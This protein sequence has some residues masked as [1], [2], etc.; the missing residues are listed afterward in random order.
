MTGPQ[1]GRVG[2]GWWAAITSRLRRRRAAWREAA[3]I[4][5]LARRPRS[6]LIVGVDAL[7][8]LVL[9][10]L[11][12]LA[13]RREGVV[14]VPGKPW[15]IAESDQFLYGP[16]SAAWAQNALALHQGRLAD[17]DPHR[18]PTWT[19]FTV[20]T[21]RAFD[22]DVALAGHLVNR[23]E[24][25]LLGP[26]LYL[27][28]RLLGLRG[29]AFAAGV[30][31]VS[32]PH[33]LASACRFGIDPTVT[34]LVPLM[35]LAARVAGGRW[36]FAPVAGAVAGL[37]MVS[38]LTALAFP[39][40]GLLLLVAS[41][42]GWW[43]RLAAA[44][45]YSAAVFLVFRWVF[46]VF[47]MLPNEFFKD[48]LAEGIT[49]T[50][51][52]VG[53]VGRAAARESALSLLQ[54]NAPLALNAALRSITHT[55][56]PVGVPWALSVALI[57]LGFIGPNAVRRVRPPPGVA[58]ARHLSGR[59][60]RSLA[61]GVAVASAC[62]PLI[63]FAAA[64]SPERYS[65]NLLPVAALLMVRGGATLVAAVVHAASFLPA[66]HAFRWRIEAGIAAL[67]AIGWSAGEW[68]EP[69]QR[70][71]VLAP[72][73]ERNA[74]AVGRA[75]AEHF[76]AGIGAASCLREALPYAGLLYCP[77][78]VCPFTDNEPGY[79][80]C[81]E[82]IRKE[83]PGTGDIPLIVTDDLTPEQCPANRVHF[84]A[85]V[86]TRL[87]PVATAGGSRIYA[88]PRTGDL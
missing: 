54:T 74:L 17:L 12:L 66:L 47:P 59:V 84:D 85:W 26:V 60:I 72:A 42:R 63:A 53:E 20:G 80:R 25:L 8:A 52:D 1:Q 48:S 40:C 28:G 4:E 29:F 50:G 3:A 23:A 13:W 35:L 9:F 22:V 87:A 81:V 15:W 70:S 7:A 41:G 82:I 77:N 24:H 21:M 44:L 14:S 64:K 32:Q 73:F 61:E 67:L 56:A 57:W 6:G 30:I 69:H 86:E 88:L 76:P 33:L 38:H 39:I 43:R 45:L 18:L 36:W 46:S 49:P 68:R 71:A 58:V 37:T 55:F 16:D 2:G 34:L 10:V 62:A 11:P 78:T 5:A 79:R 27:L 31:V 51:D 65:D 75:L 19:L 83:C